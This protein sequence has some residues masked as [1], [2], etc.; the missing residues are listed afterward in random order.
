MLLVSTDVSDLNG[1]Y[2]SAT[3]TGRRSRRVIKLQRQAVKNIW[4]QGKVSLERG[5]STSYP[6]LYELGSQPCLA[7]LSRAGEPKLVK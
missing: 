1:N 5:Q 7:R 4:A 2:L 3:A 6:A